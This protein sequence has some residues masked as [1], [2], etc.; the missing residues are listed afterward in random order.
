MELVL[1][2]ISSRHNLSGALF[3]IRENICVRS[4]IYRQ[5]LQKGQETALEDDVWPLFSYKKKGFLNPVKST[6]TERRPLEQKW[7]LSL[8]LKD[9]AFLENLLLKSYLTSK[10][11]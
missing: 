1:L 5:Y 6:L 4:S 3:E 2:V 10:D 7:R 9:F 11:V 8:Y